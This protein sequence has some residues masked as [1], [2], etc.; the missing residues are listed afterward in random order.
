MTGTQGT[1]LS[2]HSDAAHLHWWLLGADMRAKSVLLKT[3]SL[4]E[5]LYQDEHRGVGVRE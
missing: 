2:V 3:V 4:L 1:V 5:H